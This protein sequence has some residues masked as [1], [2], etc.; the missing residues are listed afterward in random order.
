LLA[1]NFEF[2]AT[3]DAL[4]IMNVEVFSFEGPFTE[5]EALGHAEINFLTKTPEEL[6]DF[7]APLQSKD[8]L[9]TGARIH[10]QIVLMNMKQADNE[11]DY[12]QRVEKDVGMKVEK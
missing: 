8:T 10:L 3:E 9:V 4:A 6:A 12:F 11:T 2:N 7:W 5:A 1:E